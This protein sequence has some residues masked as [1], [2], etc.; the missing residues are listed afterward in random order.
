MEDEMPTFKLLKYPVKMDTILFF[1]EWP[2]FGLCTSPSDQYYLAYSYTPENA[3]WIL[4]QVSRTAI[5]D[6]FNNKMSMYDV[7]QNA[8]EKWIGTEDEL[9]QRIDQFSDDELPKKGAMYGRISSIEIDLIKRLTDETVAIN[10]HE[11]T[12][13]KQELNKY[14]GHK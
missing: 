8:K 3:A 5:V 10:R 14:E 1:Y 6:M 4:A 13:T 2:I 7:M 12:F 9:F 11:E